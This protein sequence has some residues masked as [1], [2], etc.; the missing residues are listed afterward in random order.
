MARYPT[1]EEYASRNA[2]KEGISRCNT[3]LSKNPKDVNLLITK[4]QL[5]CDSNQE[6]AA[7]L[8]QIVAHT[9]PIQDIQSLVNV[10]ASVILA[11]KNAFP[12]PLTSG[13]QVSA[14][15]TAA[16]KSA[17][18]SYL[19]LDILSVR[20][21]QAVIDNR[22]QDAQQTLIAWKAFQPKNRS[23]YMAHAAYTQLL[24]TSNE[25]LQA[26]LAVMLAKKA[27]KENFD[28]EK[29]LD[30]RV[31]G[32]IL[33]RQ[34]MKEDLEGIRERPFRESREVYEA[35][36]LSEKVVLPTANTTNNAAGPSP[37][38]K[39]ETN[40]ARLKES[41]SGS[42][43]NSAP[44]ED[45]VKLAEETIRLFHNAISDQDLARSRGPA[46][47]AFLAISSLVHVFTTSGSQIPLLQAAFIAE[48]LLSHNPH[49]HEARLIL[50]YLY[51]RLR[52]GTLAAH[53]YNSLEIKEVQNDTV[54]HVLFTRL[55]LTQPFRST[56]STSQ[57]VLDP[58]ERS[59]KALQIY[60]RHESRLADTEAGVPD[61]GQS[62]MIFDLQALRATLRTSLPRRMLLLEHRRIARMTGKAGS[63]SA[64]DALGPRV[65][66]NWRSCNDSRD[67]HAAFEY[68]FNV[69]EALYGDGKI[70]KVGERWML[71]ILAADVAASLANGQV[72]LI[73][74]SQ[75]LLQLLEQQL[76]DS[77]ESKGVNEV[78]EK[79]AEITRRTLQLLLSFPRTSTTSNDDAG[80]KARSDAL[81]D[82]SACVKDL[83]L[84]DILSTPASTD[85][86]AESLQTHY[87]LLDVFRTILATCR[88]L[89]TPPKHAS[90][91]DDLKAGLSDLRSLVEDLVR[92]VMASARKGR[93]A[94]SV[95]NLRDQMSSGTAGHEGRGKDVWQSLERSGTGM[96]GFVDA[97][98]ASAREGWEGVEKV[99]R[100]P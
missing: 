71:L 27:V 14:L 33:A 20:F 24:S 69:E 23:I 8:D 4:L 54:G 95:R 6:Y 22:L 41:F 86:L 70:G 12:I 81:T 92:E 87:A 50:V 18:T 78:E 42:V 46:D 89:L 28:D 74:D 76:T 30:C 93:D 52:L 3:L 67:F 15:W 7:T 29:D 1:F 17:N 90:V 43:K 98:V 59:A 88:R 65:L 48:T 56:L 11:Q 66:A 100:L 57:D 63:K 96:E 72:P 21:S 2:H 97:V 60:P 99:G 44:E 82:L 35:L 94:L 80:E 73:E 40:V 84:N 9:P 26:R 61:H 13:P 16:F 45:F 77:K 37:R 5:L 62:G 31:V 85:I 49:I 68:G 51:M 32:Q 91:S 19:K 79:C 58:H 47:A 38:D 10:E 36:G 75:T 55:S 39:L 25:D 53:F 83:P 64:V 34:G